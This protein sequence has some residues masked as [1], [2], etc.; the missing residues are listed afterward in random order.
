[1]DRKIL[2]AGIAIALCIVIALIAIPIGARIS[3][4]G[5]GAGGIEH[6]A[7]TSPVVIR[8][9]FIDFTYTMPSGRT[10]GPLFR[11]WYMDSRVFNERGEKIALG[12]SAVFCTDEKN[13]WQD[14]VI[15]K[16]IPKRGDKVTIRLDARTYASGT[17]ID[18][19]P[20]EPLLKSL[21][22]PTGRRLTIEYVVGEEQEGW[23]RGGERVLMD[24][25]GNLHYKVETIGLPEPEFVPIVVPTMPPVVTPIPVVPRPW[26]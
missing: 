8:V 12:R 5:R 10:P 3:A 7:P 22:D 14:L 4:S 24:W 26:R 2:A 1:M 11:W 13:V 19:S 15:R 20:E 25:D 9:N 23:A 18:L 21:D 6:Q 17:Y 16:N